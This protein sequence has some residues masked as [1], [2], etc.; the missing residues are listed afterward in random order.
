MRWYFDVLQIIIWILMGVLGGRIL[1]VYTCAYS[2]TIINGAIRYMA[3]YYL[4]CAYRYPISRS[5]YQETA[6]YWQERLVDSYCE[7]SAYYDPILLFYVIWGDQGNIYGD[8]PKES[9]M[10]R[11]MKDN[12]NDSSL[13]NQPQEAVGLLVSLI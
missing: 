13:Y 1:D 6:W 4:F 2:Y 7:P 12:K 10:D 9:Y 8:S 3:F 11:I 5:R